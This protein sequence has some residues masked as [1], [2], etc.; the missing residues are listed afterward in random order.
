MSNTNVLK[1]LSPDELV[2]SLIEEIFSSGT[3]IDL[4]TQ[5][6]ISNEIVSS[7]NPYITYTK[8]RSDILTAGKIARENAAQYSTYL[9]CLKIFVF[10]IG[11]VVIFQPISNLFHSSRSTPMTN[12]CIQ[13][14][15]STIKSLCSN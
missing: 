15:N 12:E 5:N 9:G 11:S 2:A 8:I 1:I 10:I 3:G 6:Y 7:E 14:D 13:N 4:E